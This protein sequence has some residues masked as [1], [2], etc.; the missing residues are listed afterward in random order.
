MSEGYKQFCLT[1]IPWNI[2]ERVLSINVEMSNITFSKFSSLNAVG[3]HKL[4]TF[5]S[6]NKYFLSTYSMLGAGT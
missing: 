5:S 6:C 4:L 1:D 2:M 3:K